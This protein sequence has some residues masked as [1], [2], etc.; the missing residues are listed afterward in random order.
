MTDRLITPYQ[1]PS[2]DKVGGK[3]T[4]VE[5]V[6]FYGNWPCAA[7]KWVTKTDSSVHSVT[8]FDNRDIKE[9]MCVKYGK[10]MRGEGRKTPKT[11]QAN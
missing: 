1:T 3:Y 9:K 5:E 4:A 8:F 7:A 11:K 2:P 6:K 10:K